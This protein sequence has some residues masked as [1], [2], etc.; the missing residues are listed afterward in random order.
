MSP[1]RWHALVG[2]HRNAGC[3]RAPSAGRRGRSRA[4]GCSTSSM[5]SGSIG[6]STRTASAALQ[7][8]LASTRSRP[9]IA[10]ADAPQ[11][12][13]V[14]GR[15]ELDLEH[16]EV[17]HGLE[18][19]LHL[20][21]RRHARA[22]RTRAARRRDRARAA[23]TPAGQASCRSSR[24]APSRSRRA[25]RRGRAAVRRAVASIA[26]SANGSS[27]SAAPTRRAPAPPGPG[28]RR[29]SATG[30]ASPRPVD[31]LVLEPH[32]RVLSVRVSRRRARCGTRTWSRAPAVHAG[33]AWLPSRP[34]GNAPGAPRTEL[35]GSPEGRAAVPPSRA[36]RAA[37]RASR[38]RR[39]APASGAA[40]KRTGSV[41]GTCSWFSARA[42]AARAA[43]S[44]SEQ[45]VERD[46]DHARRAHP[47]R[48]RIPRRHAGRG[49]RRNR[50]ASGPASAERITSRPAWWH[51]TSAAGA[52][53]CSS[54]RRHA[55]E[56]PDGATHPAP[57][58]AR[59][60]RRAAASST[61][62][63]ITPATKSAGTASTATPPSAIEDPGLAGGDER[64]AHAAAAT[65]RAR[66]R[67][68]PSSC[69]RCSR[70]PR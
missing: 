35:R 20:L 64:R 66:S 14:A 1:R 49:Q 31:P 50:A 10:G 44:S 21:G 27:P 40:P 65:A 34:L 60:R 41:A 32:Q 57:R 23:S 12:V 37:T 68:R 19:A 52:A 15:P 45:R 51:S 67:A 17:D 54:A 39:I 33:G 9:L 48:P 69:R 28:S 4:T 5:S 2:E 56:S 59:R 47:A 29:S 3:A 61:S 13:D 53:P 7:A 58:P 38:A 22:S 18:L 36:S 62:R 24:A 16:R 43:V 42:H 6:R 11:V 70:C 46:A 25:R 55:R 30:D 26:S 8:V 63:S